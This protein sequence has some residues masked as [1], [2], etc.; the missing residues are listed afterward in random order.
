[1]FVLLILIYMAF[2]SLGL[3][4]S[5]L[6]AAWPVMRTDLGAG[7]SMAGAISAVICAGTVVSSL[8]SSRVIHRFGTGKVTFVSVFLT[9]ISLLGISFS[10][11]IALIFLLA[12]PLGL[13]AG[14][15][16]AALNNFVSNHY[17][18]MHMNWLHCF[19][20]LGA[21]AGPIVMSYFIA[22]NGQWR[23][24]Y[25]TIAIIQFVLASILLVTLPLW[26]KA[27]SEASEEKKAEFLSNSQAV[28]K[29]GVK[30]AMLAFL[31]YCGYEVGTTL[32]AASY[33]KEQ[34]GLTAD[35]AASWAALVYAGI[36][37]GRFIS[38]IASNKLSSTFLIRL[39]SA[40]AAT[41]LIILILPLPSSACI[42]GLA[43]LGFGAA[44]FYPSMIHETPRRFGK[45]SSQTITGL[46]MASAYIG[47][48][49]FPPIIGFL[50]SVF[51]LG[52]FPWI[53]LALAVSALALSERAEAAT[54]KESV[55]A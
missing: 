9:A 26:K 55:G 13:G 16:D 21:T 5:L 19:W 39:G 6:G 18:A 29:K 42:W 24:G 32:W 36:T 2:I 45:E 14:S 43:L 17:K 10:G 52:V 22:Q 33:L 37:I 46:Q 28:K 30:A 23:K 25:G 51:S 44:P 35:K 54:R 40:I 8:L 20:G 48:T 31:C 4:D 50:S 47:S 38:G 34:R 27:G 11:S 1:M 7:L 49:C 3:P 41:G 12:V 15:V 53:L